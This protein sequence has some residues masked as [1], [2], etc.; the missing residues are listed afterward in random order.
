MII[1]LFIEKQMLILPRLYHIDFWIKLSDKY[2]K[3]EIY[4]DVLRKQY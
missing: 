3:I 1:W 2:Y 4:V